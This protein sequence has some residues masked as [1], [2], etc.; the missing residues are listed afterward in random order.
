[1]V[2]LNPHSY[3]HFKNSR[4]LRALNMIIYRYHSPTPC[5]TD[6]ALLQVLQS[7]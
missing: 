4:T 6:A 2:K 7:S 3:A 1:M 5:V